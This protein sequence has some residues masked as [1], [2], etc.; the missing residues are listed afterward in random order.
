RSREM[1]NILLE[2]SVWAARGRREIVLTGVNLGEYRSEGRGL[3]DLIDAL[4]TIDGLERV[5]ISSIEPTT[6]SDR[7]LEQMAR[8]G[9]L[10]PYLHLPLQSGS[11]AVLSAMGRR[12]TRKEYVDFVERA[13][14]KVPRLGL[15]TDVM[16]GF[17]GEGEAEF[18]ETLSLVETV[19]FSYLH[20]FP[21]SMRKGTRVTKMG[22]PA[23]PSRV[24]KERGKIL[25]DLSKKKREIFY[26]GFVG[27]NVEVLFE[28]R[29]EEGLFVG[30]TDNYM[31]VGVPADRDLSGRVAPVR[32]EKVEDGL[33]IGAFNSSVIIER[34]DR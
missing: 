32:I 33:A 22:L 6:V 4:E 16:V 9:K 2:A 30:L 7:L 34:Q 13:V 14:A 24:V 26:N 3:S 19:P 27:K 21:F 11:D 18:R 29:N 25:L 15:G 1:E 8:G 20:L 5:R 23:V 17:P 10:C 31:R 12:Y 28:T